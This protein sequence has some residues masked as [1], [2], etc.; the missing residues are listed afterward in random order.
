MYVDKRLSGIQAVQTLSRLNRAMRRVEGP[1][2][3]SDFANDEREDILEAFKTYY[4]TAELS[5]TSDPN[6]VLNL[7][8]KLD[9]QGHYDDAEVDRVI[10]AIYRERN[11]QAEVVAALTPMSDRL[12]K[13]YRAAGRGPTWRRWPGPT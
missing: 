4:A 6:I 12:L 8:T 9:S 3:S 5:S 13:R 11:S 7:R 2:T 1:R 10:G